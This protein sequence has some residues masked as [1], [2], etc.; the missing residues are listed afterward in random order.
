MSFSLNVFPFQYLFLSMCLL[1]NILP[2]HWVLLSM[3]SLLNSPLLSIFPLNVL[4]S[5]CLSLSM[6]SPLNLF[7]SQ[8]PPLPSLPLSN[9]NIPPSQNH[10]LSIFFPLNVLLSQCFSLLISFLLISSPLNSFSPLRLKPQ[11]FSFSI[12]S[13]FKIFLNIPPFHCFPPIALN[14]HCIFLLIFS[15]LKVFTS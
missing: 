6:S 9:P 8:C 14:S 1:L 11:Y 3:F 12:S 4:P 10:P 15:F 13:P 7:P 2:S 5:R